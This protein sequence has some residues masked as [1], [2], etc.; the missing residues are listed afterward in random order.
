MRSVTNHVN[1]G[2]YPLVPM[3]YKYFESILVQV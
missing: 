3:Q 2:N 1:A